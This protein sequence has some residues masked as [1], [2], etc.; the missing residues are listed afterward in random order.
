MKGTIIKLII[1][2]LI[3]IVISASIGVFIGMLAM[4]EGATLEINGVLQENFDTTT[5]AIQ[6]ALIVFS[7][8]TLSFMWFYIIN[9]SI[10][11]STYRATKKIE[12]KDVIYQRE[13]SEDYNSAVASYIIDGVV[14]T[15]Q[16]YQAVLVELE[17]RGLIYKEN[18]KYKINEENNN[19]EGLLQNQKLV[20]EQI[21][22][23]LINLHTFKCA[24]VQDASDRGYTKTNG[25]LF[26]I[27]L[28]SIFMI[29]P[30]GLWLMLK[31]LFGA[32]WA[33]ALTEKGKK[34]KDKILKLKSYLVNFSDL[35]QLETTDHNIWGEYL[36][37]AISLNVNK[38]LK[39][40]KIEI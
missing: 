18:K 8:L 24:V 14:E 2:F 22:Q 31:I 39:V 19:R 33:M 5:F 11:I 10:L 3:T 38:K 23:G 7:I 13:L 29:P 27:S 30:I 28:L 21:R 37:Y 15:K 35:H 36:A 9:I 16:D 26:I 40:N 34:E 17:S 32:P 6:M 4:Q 25:T 20:L 12:N 1:V